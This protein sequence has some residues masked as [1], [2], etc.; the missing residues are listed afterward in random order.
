MTDAKGS[1]QGFDIEIAKAL[2]ETIEAECSFSSDQFNNIAPSL[3][4][5]KYDAWVSAITIND[6][7]KQKI[8]LTDPYFSSTAQLIATKDTVFN[9]APVEITGKTIGVVERGRYIRFLTKTYADLIKIKAFTT[10]DNAFAALIKGSV[11]AVIDDTM[12]L[13]HWR[14]SQKNPEKY[15]LIGL[16]A[17][18]SDLVWHKYGIAVAKDNPLLAETLNHAISQIKADGT[19]N[20]IIKKYFAN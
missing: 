2:C 14:F 10:R 7:H 12:V 20:E 13:K 8:L 18:Y 5:K 6:K 1:L 15:R 3:N 9:G 4:S 16:P 19:Y 17:K 11:D